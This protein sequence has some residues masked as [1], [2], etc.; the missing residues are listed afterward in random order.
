MNR[1]CLTLLGVVLASTQAGAG[2]AGAQVV[3]L[4]IDTAY[5]RVEGRTAR[6]WSA[7]MDAGAQAAGLRPPAVGNSHLQVWWT[8]RPLVPTA[9]GCVAWVPDVE[10]RIHYTMPHLVPAPGA[11]PDDVREWRTF[12]AALWRH[13]EGHAA[14]A[15]RKGIETRDSLNWIRA[16]TCAELRV[17]LTAARDAVSSKYQ[18]LDD[19]Y[20]ARTRNANDRG[21]LLPRLGIRVDT[22]F[23]DTVP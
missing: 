17:R 5:Y 3:R 13:E 19:A 12:L 21:V 11:T 18:A 9:S 6:E 10:V 2:A 7:S 15:L 23:R 16:P 4:V 8:P 14:R 20:D 1:R 22:T